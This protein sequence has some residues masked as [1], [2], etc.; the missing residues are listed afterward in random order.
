MTLI[1]NKFFLY[2]WLF[3]IVFET[4][5]AVYIWKD[6]SK[7]IKSNEFIIMLKKAIE[8]S[9]SLQLLFKT[10]FNPVTY[11]MMY[12]IFVLISPLLFPASLFGIIKRATGYKSKLERK[13]EEEIKRMEQ[14]KKRSEEFMRTEGRGE[15]P[16]EHTII[17]PPKKE[18]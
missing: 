18:E 15:F 16:I 2:Y 6:W 7:K 8:Y 1:I 14:A 3:S 9:A 5:Y 17:I 10:I 4:I 11:I 12:I 13:S